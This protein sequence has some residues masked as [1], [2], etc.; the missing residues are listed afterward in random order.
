MTPEQI[1][2]VFSSLGRIEQKIDSHIDTVE[3]HAEHDD[4][5]HKLLF[6]RVETLQLAHAR[7]RGFITAIAAVGSAVAGGVGYLLERIWGHP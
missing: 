5:V 6:S 4:A 1:A 2:E 7:Q 3:K